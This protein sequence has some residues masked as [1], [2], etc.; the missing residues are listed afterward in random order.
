M[1]YPSTAPKKFSRPLL[2]LG[3]QFVWPPTDGG[4]EGIHGAL[5]S[6]NRLFD[7]IYACPCSHPTTESLSYFQSLGID[8]RP[9]NFEPNDGIRNILSATFQLKPFK[10]HK[11]GNHQA[12]SSF[13][14]NLSNC[15][16]EA[17]LCFHAHMMQLGL[18]LREHFRWKCPIILR[19]HNIEFELVN[20]YRASLPLPLRILAFPFEL[21]T[22][23]AEQRSWRLAD[24]TAFLSDRDF[25][26]AKLT[27]K[28]RNP[29]L[30]REGV[31]IPPLRDT[32]KSMR[33]RTLLIPLNPKA[34]QSL[35]NLRMF[36]DRYWRIASL[37]PEMEGICLAITG[38]DT[39][40]F[41]ALFDITIEEQRNLRIKALGFLPRLADAFEMSALLIS[42]TFV[43][44]GIRKKMLEGM[45]NQLPVIASDLDIDTCNFLDP[46][47]NI[48]RLGT[49]NDF[50][51][52]VTD[53]LSDHV[54]WKRI[55][56]AG[57]K[58]VEEFANWDVFASRISEEVRQ[59]QLARQPD[60]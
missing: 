22:R 53:L 13:S 45:A 19:E 4:K 60:Q 47:I 24:A 23:R 42:P 46:P 30:A 50:V 3:P 32:N 59:C 39:G 6:L 57:R 31:P 17:I 14:A 40:K 43:G 7:V 27:G 20:S 44:G 8:Y 48:R 1:S 37:R 2:T 38:V 18:R 16:P 34:T 10:F 21:L 36:I 52:T 56:S 54:E 5:V 58:T 11:Y 29:V 49:I 33:S 15:E 35:G 51:A 25:N 41:E 28:V 55:S 26:T 9:V 12:V